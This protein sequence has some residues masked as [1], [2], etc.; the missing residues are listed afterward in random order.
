MTDFFMN[1]L[2][3][4]ELAELVN[5][6]IKQIDTENFLKSIISARGVNLLSKMNP[7][8]QGSTLAPGKPSEV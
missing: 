3:A 4:A 8:T 5:I 6:I 7:R 2:S 1:N